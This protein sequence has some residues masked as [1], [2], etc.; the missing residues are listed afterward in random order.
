MKVIQANQV[1]QFLSVNPAISI[2]Q[3]YNL[4]TQGGKNFNY[5]ISARGNGNWN[6]LQLACK[7]GN[8]DLVNALL[9]MGANPNFSRN[10][11]LTPLYDAIDIGNLDIVKMLIEHGAKCDKYGDSVLCTYLDFAR[12]KGNP[13]IITCIS[14]HI[15]NTDKVTECTDLSASQRYEI[16]KEF[17]QAIKESDLQKAQILLKQH[18]INLP[19][20]FLTLAMDVLESQLPQ[21]ILNWYNC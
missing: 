18:E 13:E 8:K 2:L 21:V 4:I 5:Y 19:E 17:K 3:F 6:A 20:I 12:K 16:I 10:G 15:K 7:G 9:K 11:G 1:L 14:E